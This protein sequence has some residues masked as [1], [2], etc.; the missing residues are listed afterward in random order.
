M[1]ILGRRMND[2]A[3]LRED[4]EYLE[5]SCKEEGTKPGWKPKED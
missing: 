4:S 2:S 3:H 5:G 1:D